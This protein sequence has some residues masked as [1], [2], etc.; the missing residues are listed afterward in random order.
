[1]RPNPLGLNYNRKFACKLDKYPNIQISNTC[2]NQLGESDFKQIIT[3]V[4]EIDSPITS[5][6][7]FVL[8]GS[9]CP[10]MF[11]NVQHRLVQTVLIAYCIWA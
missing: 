10:Q 2:K 4:C 5:S 3:F 6:I 1:M 9:Q 8:I 11:Q 7:K